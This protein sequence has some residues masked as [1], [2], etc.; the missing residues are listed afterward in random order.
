[1][2][3]QLFSQEAELRDTL[4]CGHQVVELLQLQQD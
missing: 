4:T 2:V 1:M 3:L